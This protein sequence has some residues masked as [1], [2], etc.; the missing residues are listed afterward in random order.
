MKV[1]VKVHD[2]IDRVLH[3][4]E[5]PEKVKIFGR[6]QALRQEMLFQEPYPGAPVAAARDVDEH[7]RDDSRLAGLHQG[8]NLETLVHRAETSGEKRDAVRLLHEVDLA[9]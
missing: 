1:S 7:E 9:G 3:P 5:H 4:V 6:D 2:L 8:E